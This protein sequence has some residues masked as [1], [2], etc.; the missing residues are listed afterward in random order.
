MIPYDKN[1]KK[2]NVKS[3]RDLNSSPSLTWRVHYTES[4]SLHFLPLALLG[5]WLIS[6]SC[7]GFQCTIRYTVDT[8][9]S[10]LLNWEPEVYTI[11]TGSQTWFFVEIIS[12]Q[13]GFP[14]SWRTVII[15]H[16]GPGFP[17]SVPLKDRPHHV[18]YEHV[19]QQVPC[20]RK[21]A[22]TCERPTGRCKME[23]SDARY[24]SRG[25]RVGSQVYREHVF[26]YMLG[27]LLFVH[28]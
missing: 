2:K 7:W 16:R 20:T 22:V 12:I 15:S 13:S 1:S 23:G 9:G 10:L 3:W 26:S 27:I 11:F 25:W 6:D 8:D 24:E 28:L 17:G 19:S 5:Y 4:W 18:W 14:V 21:S